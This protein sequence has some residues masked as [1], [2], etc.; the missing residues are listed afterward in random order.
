MPSDARSL[1]GGA[2][3]EAGS[4]AIQIRVFK[5]LFIR[6]MMTRYGRNNIGFLWLFVEPMLFTIMVVIMRAGIKGMMVGNIPIIAFAI[7]GFAT[8]QMWRSMPS[9]VLGAVASNRSL[10]YHRQVTIPDVYWSRM[11][12]EVAGSSVSLITLI[13]VAAVLEWAPWP[14]DVLKM[15]GGFGM[16]VWFG[17]GLGLIIGPLSERWPVVGNVWRPVSYLFFPLSGIAFV[18]DI[19]PPGLQR[20]VL[21]LPQ[22]HSLE[23]FR[24]GWFGSTFTA[25]YDMSYAA[26]WNLGLTFVGLAL[27]R[28]V[29]FDTSSE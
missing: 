13:L 17:L 19:L 16:L 12:L 25:H 14:E 1:G 20:I 27:L 18:V 28:Q 3:A 26:L 29:K 22:V 15:L 7:S 21:W 23:Y 6:E 4:L 5:A 24:E 9:R 8:I 10:L 11:A 2:K